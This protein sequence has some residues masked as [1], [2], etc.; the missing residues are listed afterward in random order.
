MPTTGAEV[1][2]SV[3]LGNPALKNSF[4]FQS[5]HKFDLAQNNIP[6]F[7]TLKQRDIKD[8]ATVT[9]GRRSKRNPTAQVLGKRYRGQEL[10]EVIYGTVTIS[11]L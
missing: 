8:A 5:N 4:D 2:T 11:V 9:R 10:E 3:I 6:P 7:P 1:V